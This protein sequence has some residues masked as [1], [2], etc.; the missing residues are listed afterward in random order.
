MYSYDERGQGKDGNAV[1]SLRM[2]HLLSKLKQ[3][4]DTEN[5]PHNLTSARDSCVEQSKSH[6]TMLFSCF[7]SMTFYK[8][9]VLIF[10]DA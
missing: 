8:R 1:C 4:I 10:L 5:K 2:N 6:L 3:Q 7:L 9:V